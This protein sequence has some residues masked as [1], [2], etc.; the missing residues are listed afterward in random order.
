MI[1]D[2]DGERRGVIDRDGKVIL[3]CIWNSTWNGISCEKRRIIF[4]KDGKQGVADFEGN[5]IVEPVYKKIYCL[6]DPLLSIDIGEGI[7]KKCGL[8]TH[9]GKAVLPPKFRFIQ[10]CDDGYF[11]CRDDH[12]STMYRWESR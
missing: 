3:P 12:G 4:E 8:I 1:R 7:D 11:I 5:I 9:D 6:D 10:W 2:D